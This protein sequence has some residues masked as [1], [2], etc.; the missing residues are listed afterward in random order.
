MWRRPDALIPLDD[1]LAALGGN[2]VM[3]RGPAEVPLAQVAGTSARV[4]DFDAEFRLRNRRLRDRWTRVAGAMAGGD[5]PPVELIQLGSL[6]FVVDGHHRVSVARSL[7]RATIAANVQRICTIAFGMAC[8]RAAHLPNKAAER[9]FLERV[10]LPDAVREDLWLDQ[11][12][13]WDHLADAAEAWGFRQSLAGRR[14]TGRAELAAGWWAEE[15]G[16]VL[17][18]ARAA[19]VGVGRRD[20]ELYVSLRARQWQAWPPGPDELAQAVIS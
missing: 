16:P 2:G 7:G 6:Y 15:V 18:R 5:L 20:V 8:I 12:V 9:R 17:A 1:A 13:E 3:E 14:V 11:P 19:G 4:D 10:P